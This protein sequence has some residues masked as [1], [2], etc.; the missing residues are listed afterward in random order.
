MNL[1]EDKL[2]LRAILDQMMAKSEQRLKELTS[3]VQIFKE[4]PEYVEPQADNYRDITVKVST[5][6]EDDF[7]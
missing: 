2:Q 1:P 4:P 6:C 5:P 7:N 3:P